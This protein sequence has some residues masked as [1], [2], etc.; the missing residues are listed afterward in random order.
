MA[1]WWSFVDLLGRSRTCRGLVNLSCS[2]DDVARA[3][4]IY[5]GK[6]L[7]VSVTDVT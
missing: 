4:N 5:R 3:L 7:H 1:R 2:S 6:F